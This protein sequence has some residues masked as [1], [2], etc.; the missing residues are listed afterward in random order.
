MLNV[1]YL[2]SVADVGGARPEAVSLSNV[3][4]LPRAYLV[5]RA[6]FFGTHEEILMYMKSGDFDPAAEVLLQ[7]PQVS[8][9]QVP[10]GVPPGSATLVEY[11]P[12]RVGID[13]EVESDSYL[14]LSDV[15]YPGWKAMLDGEEV[16]LLMANYA[17][18]AVRLG[19]GS[20]T[21]RMEYVPLYFRIGLIF[22]AAGAGLVILMLASRRRFD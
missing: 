9:P 2:M 6:R 14:F 12:H 22:S 4:Y 10:T 18:R 20:H 8:T 13:V 15:H 21:V 16:E 5:P 3:G 7:G 1:K 11:T 19:P 17:F